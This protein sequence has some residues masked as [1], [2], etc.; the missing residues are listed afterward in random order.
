MFRSPA[1][2]IVVLAASGLSDILDGWYARRFHQETATGAAL[3]GV[4][5]KLFALSVLATL[6]LSR[7]LS[8][9]EAFVLSAREIGEALLLCVAVFLRP[10]KA[11]SARS[12]NRLGKLATVLQFTSVIVVI[13][14]RGP[15]ALCVYATGTCGAL[16]AIAYG[17]REFGRGPPP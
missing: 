2:A 1:H 8:L 3:D 12:A 6:V 13:L 7:T 11:D 4:M 9:F 17:W 5:D 16:A 10:R 14:D 15:R